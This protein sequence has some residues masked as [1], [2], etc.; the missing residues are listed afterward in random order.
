MTTTVDDMNSSQNN[1]QQV[2]ETS[3][4]FNSPF[5]STPQVQQNF[6]NYPQQ[7][8]APTYQQQQSSYYVPQNNYGAQTPY[9]QSQ[10]PPYIPT[11]PY[12]QQSMKSS[13]VYVASDVQDFTHAEDKIERNHSILCIIC[14]ICGFF[15]FPF[16][17]LA[18]VHSR[19]CKN[20]VIRAI[21]IISNVLFSFALGIVIFYVFYYLFLLWWY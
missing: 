13:T 11:T 10:F 2:Y 14:F 5:N 1:Q 16:F 9:Q 21:G 15:L 3:N 7:Q 17:A 12:D 6:D 18:Y 20:G 8:A 19:K 4:Q